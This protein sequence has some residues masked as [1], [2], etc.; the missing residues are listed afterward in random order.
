MAI[1]CETSTIG[2]SVGGIFLLSERHGL[3]AMTALGGT[4]LA[5]HGERTKPLKFIFS[6]KVDRKCL[7]VYSSIK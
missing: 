6:R 3:R 7:V 4:F 5:K 1:A 2:A